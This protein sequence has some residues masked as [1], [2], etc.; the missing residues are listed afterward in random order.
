MATPYKSLDAEFG[1]KHEP[2]RDID[3]AVEDGL[4]RLTRNGRL[5]KRTLRRHCKLIFL[6]EF[7]VGCCSS[8]TDKEIRL[9]LSVIRID[10]L[11]LLSLRA[12]SFF[13]ILLMIDLAARYARQAGK[14]T[15]HW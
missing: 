7:L 13:A 11:S 14:N 6:I 12:R 1:E 9:S 5:G 2:A 4:K 10:L 3:T 8:P 15:V